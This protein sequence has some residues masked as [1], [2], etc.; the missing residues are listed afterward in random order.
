MKHG[1]GGTASTTS[2]PTAAIS[3]GVVPDLR[4]SAVLGSDAWYAV[5]QDGLLA[6]NGMAAFG[7]VLNR[8]RIT[9]IRAYVI[10]EAQKAKAGQAQDIPAR[11]PAQ[12]GVGL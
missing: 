9:G 6:N 1:A 2:P 10:S 11:R 12:T 7:D 5:V 4:H 8:D 3:G